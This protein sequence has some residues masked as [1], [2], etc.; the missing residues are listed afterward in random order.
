MD[1]RIK[2]IADYY[3]YENQKGMLMEEMGELMQAVNK[4]DR[5]CAEGDLY[6]KEYARWKI[7]Q[8]IADVR[9]M[10]DQMTYLLNAEYVADQQYIEKIE[11]QLER[12]KDEQKG[13]EPVSVIYGVHQIGNPKASKEYIWRVPKNMECPNV[14]E[15]V[16]VNT[17][18]GV[19]F[20]MVTRIDAMPLK[21]AKH[22]KSMIDRYGDEQ[23]E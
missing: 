12:I 4:Y 23:Q 6:G 17:C 2:Q 11:R 3:G 22:H 9:I 10:L 19:Q 20:A 15:V 13:N 18:C 14:G 7:V 8:E 16:S 1:E 21:D 5:A